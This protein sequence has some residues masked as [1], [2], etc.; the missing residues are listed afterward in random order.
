M[1][2]SSDPGNRLPNI[3]E[4]SPPDKE[5]LN[6]LPSGSLEGRTVSWLSSQFGKIANFF[7]E[8]L[9]KISFLW[10][11]FKSTSDCDSA[12][13]SSFENHSITDFQ[14]KDIVGKLKKIPL[15]EI[16]IYSSNEEIQAFID[17][18]DLT[19][20][21][22]LDF[23]RVDFTLLD[24]F[25][26]EHK[27]H[28]STYASTPDKPIDQPSNLE[29]A[30]AFGEDPT[31]VKIDSKSAILKKL[32]IEKDHSI[33]PSYLNILDQMPAA[34]L[35]KLTEFLNLVETN[36]GKENVLKII[37][38]TNQNSLNKALLI[39]EG[40]YYKIHDGE[41]VP[42]MDTHKNLFVLDAKNSRITLYNQSNPM[43]DDRKMT[44]IHVKVGI[45]LDMMNNQ[46]FSPKGEIIDTVCEATSS[47][48]SHPD[49]K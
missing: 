10:N 7:I 39:K 19:K 38:F 1:S 6:P 11:S 14:T 43:I 48:F 18:K 49:S 27:F 37:K 46:I 40:L 12:S 47:I 3:H 34:V 35:E 4:V 15:K 8:I 41:R 28:R 29:E 42:L 13:E 5:S 23:S 44:H 36:F 9:S 2:I 21:F 33:Y 31:D 32:E 45:C 24:K 26:A 16:V 25:G 30:S 22:L 17:K 20:Q